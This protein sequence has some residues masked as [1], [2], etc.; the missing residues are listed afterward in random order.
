[1]NVFDTRDAFAAH[2][3]TGAQQAASTDIAAALTQGI[4][5]SEDEL[6]AA[7][8]PVDGL[9]LR[10][11]RWVLR[12]SDLPVLEAITM[13]GAALGAVAAP[14]AIAVGTVLAGL[15]AFAKFAWSAWRRSSRL[16]RDEIAVLGV[17]HTRGPLSQD[18]LTTLAM[19][20]FPQMT[21]AQVAQT[22][23]SL[24]DVELLDGDIVELVRK[25]ASGRWRV[26][27]V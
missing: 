21:Q 6:R 9:N 22:L 13:V 2:V 26:R 1:M 24:Q 10:V 8:R 5:A 14:G 3:E 16:S 15:T 25:D 18:D 17:L 11:G 7:D 27:N 19:D 23:Q 4:T 20:A 12:D